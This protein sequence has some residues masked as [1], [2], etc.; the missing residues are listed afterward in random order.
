MRL[1]RLAPF[2]FRVVD[3]NEGRAA[4]IYRRRSDEKG[5]D[6]L[7]RIAA[8]S[9]LAFT[10]GTSLL[11]D[12]AAKSVIDGRNPNPRHPVNPNPRHPELDSGSTRGALKPGEFYPMD[13][14]W[15]CRAACFAMICAGLR[16]GER[17]LKAASR[18]R[19]A[20]GNEAAWWLGMLQN[21]D[22][23]RAIRALRILTEAVE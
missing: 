2:A 7:Q 9:P 11:K 21:G 17:M 4:I 20:D 19:E 6:R 1:T 5:R 22:G 3:R 16:D 23:V 13:S 14:D 15:G 18:M 10:A 8:L 12:A